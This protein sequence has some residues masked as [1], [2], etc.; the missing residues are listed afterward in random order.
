M[1]LVFLMLCAVAQNK[2]NL[3][4]GGEHGGIDFNGDSA[5]SLY[6]P[7]NS[8]VWRTSASICDSGGNLLFYTNGFQV[9]N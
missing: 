6:R 1:S 9:F 5:V 4:M 3:W 2:V 7:D 8:I